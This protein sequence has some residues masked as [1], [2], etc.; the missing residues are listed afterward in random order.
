MMLP[1]IMATQCS[2]R[3]MHMMIAGTTH[4]AGSFS[5]VSCCHFHEKKPYYLDEVLE[6]YVLYYFN[7]GCYA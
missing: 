4:S 6:T 7:A 2:N 3:T 1:L 5:V